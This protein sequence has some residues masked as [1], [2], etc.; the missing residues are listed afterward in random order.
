MALAARLVSASC[1]RWA[2]ATAMACDG[3]AAECQ[4]RS[5]WR[6]PGVAVPER[7]CAAGWTSPGREIQGGCVAA[8]QGQQLLRAA[9]GAGNF[10][11]QGLQCLLHQV[12][13]G[14]SPCI[15]HLHLQSGQVGA[16]LVRCVVQKFSLLR[17]ERL[18]AC[19]V[20]VDG[21]HQGRM[22]AGRS[23]G[24][25]GVISS[26]LRSCTPCAKRASGRKASARVPA[27]PSTISTRISPSRRAARRTK[28]RVKSR[29][30]WV[31]SPTCTMTLVFDCPGLVPFRLASAEMGRW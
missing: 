3:Q 11:S 17:D 25:I 2:S 27:A 22:S 4:S 13:V 8:P 5:A 24:G 12:A 10:G 14:L 28:R 6:V 23:C 15:V 21:G 7:P 31:L 19:H 16:Q 1:I 30:D 26:G 18:V 20:L 9:G 29:R